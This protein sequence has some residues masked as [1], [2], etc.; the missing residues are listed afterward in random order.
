[1]TSDDAAVEP[2]MDET[3]WDAQGCVERVRQGDEDAAR[4]LM[5]RLASLVLKIVRAHR[6]GR[7]SEEDLVQSVFVKVFAKLDQFSGAVPLEHWVSRIAVNTSINE[8]NR[9]RARPELRW[10]DLSEEQEE[11]VR[12]LATS[13]AD[14]PASQT[15][16]ARE[17]VEMLL[18]KLSASDRLVI[19]LLHLE[20]RTI[21]EI[22]LIT[23]W[24]RALVKVR[25]FRARAKLRRHLDSLLREEGV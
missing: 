14:L 3:Q 5:Q 24:S 11:V 19:T 7:A 15:L 9:E 23:G 10:A 17:L 13:E 16:A 12:T 18:E 6:P 25:A 4:E 21:E 22:R 20:G 2:I 1:M 8:L